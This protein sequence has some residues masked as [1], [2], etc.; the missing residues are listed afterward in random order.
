MKN[1]GG[2]LALAKKLGLTEYEYDLIKDYLKRDPTDLETSLFSAMWSEHCSYKSSKN[3]LKNFPTTGP[4]VIQ[5]PGENA[6]IVDI[7]GGWAACFKME[8]HNHPSYLEPYQGAATGVGGILRDVFTMGARPVASLNMLRFGNPE[9]AKTKYLISRVV[10]GIGDYGNCMGVPTV[11]TDVFFDPS[12]EHNPLVNAFNIGIVKKDKIFLGNASGIGNSI[13]YVGA[14]TGRDGIGGAIMASAEFDDEAYEKKPTVQVGDPFMEKLLLEACLEAMQ[15]DYIV[16]IQ[17][18]GAAG[19]TCSTFEMADRAQS[20][21]K[22]NLSKV[23]LRAKNMTP[24][25]VMMSESQERMLLCVKKGF[26]EET[27]KL[28]SKWDLDAVVIGEVIDSPYVKIEWKGEEIGEIPVEPLVSGAPLYERPRKSYTPSSSVIASGSEAIPSPKVMR[29]PRFSTE[30]LAMTKASIM[31]QYDSMVGTNTLV[32]Y[33]DVPLIRVRENGSILALAMGSAE[34]LT[35]LNPFE[36]GKYIVL[37]AVEKLA[38]VG[39]IPL[40]LTDC[41]NFGSPEN[42]EIMWQFEQTVLGMSEACRKMNVPVVSGNVSFYNET[43]GKSIL[44]T[45]L[46]VMV[47]LIHG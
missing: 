10:K 43:N 4:N 47:G 25:E 11:G 6:G 39:A 29:S 38:S 23:P 22:I 28:F 2:N 44:P 41:L 15:T 36:G 21:V 8:S 33:H 7:G 14:K 19:L 45:P 17:D 35:Y 24:V 32:C 1:L 9:S 26:E 30:N 37:K 13:M 20:G 12:Y 46:I 3:I 5:G 34:Y 40:A 27:K 16:G 18:M 31:E 42:P